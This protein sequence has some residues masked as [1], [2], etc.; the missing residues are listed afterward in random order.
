MKFISTLLVVACVLVTLSSASLTEQDFKKM[1]IKDLRTFLD[2]RGLTCVGCQE[3]SDF[4]RMAYAN[5]DTPVV[6]GV[7]K[8]EVPDKKFWEAWSETAKQI[9]GEAV[10]KRGSDPATEPFVSVCDTVEKA[11]DAFMMQHGKRTATRL[12]KT[13]DNMLKTSYKDV[14]YEAG[15]RLFRKLVNYCLASSDM[16]AKCESLGF[17]MNAME[18]GEVGGFQSWVTNV[19]I[20]NT[21]PMYEI[22]DDQ[23]DL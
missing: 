20:E 3:K 8:R 15:V 10:T 1:K 21:N 18:G 17:V 22:I 19:G 2:E 7:S 11:T 14:Y 13:P 6:G 9:C 4:V 16:Q 23:D 12:K 5:Q